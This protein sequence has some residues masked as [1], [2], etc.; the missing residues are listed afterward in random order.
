[1]LEPCAGPTRRA[2]S[3]TAQRARPRACAGRP[4]MPISSTTSAP[5][6]DPPPSRPGRH[7]AGTA[8]TKPSRRPADTILPPSGLPVRGS[9]QGLPVVDSACRR[10]HAAPAS[11]SSSS[12]VPGPCPMSPAGRVRRT[13][14]FPGLA[15]SA[16][17]VGPAQPVLRCQMIRPGSRGVGRHDRASP[18]SITR[19][20]GRPVRSRFGVGGILP[21]DDRALDRKT[22]L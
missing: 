5:P 12:R 14:L 17:A 9:S 6:R 16:V 4:N 11:R 13:N 8:R 22:Y 18:P 10:L 7:R 3:M 20:T 1:V 19:L 2:A 15:P 21:C